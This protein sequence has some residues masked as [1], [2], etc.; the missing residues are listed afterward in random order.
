MAHPVLALLGLLSVVLIATGIWLRATPERAAP[1]AVDLAAVLPEGTEPALTSV[2]PVEPA[3]V[4]AV[5]PPGGDEPAP[6]EFAAAADDA[7]AAAAAEERPTVAAEEPFPYSALPQL[8]AETLLPPAAVPAGQ[9]GGQAIAADA[10]RVDPGDDR[11]ALGDMAAAPPAAEPAGKATRPST[12][13]A[14]AAPVAKTAEQEAAHPDSAPP[15][16]APPDAATDAAEPDPPAETAAAFAPVTYG[17]VTRT[18]PVVPEVMTVM[19]RATFENEFRGLSR[20]PYFGAVAFDGPRAVVGA[21]GYASLLAAESAVLARCQQ[22]ASNCRIGARFLPEGYDG[23]QTGTL[24]HH[25]AEVWEAYWNE[26]MQSSPI[27]DFHRAFAWSEDGAA[28]VFDMIGENAT[29]S[30]ALSRCELE[31][32]QVRRPPVPS[33]DGCRI[34]ANRTE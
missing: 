15:D 23:R 17:P 28:V 4:A 24:S 9:D 19:E 32:R 31:R 14:P 1:E 11:A 27:I 3:A 16:T 29:R 20:A 34:G 2:P 7:L 12:G 10:A 25:Q 13:T 6:A 8:N 22:L 26:P 30:M 33:A 18:L 5:A 21:G